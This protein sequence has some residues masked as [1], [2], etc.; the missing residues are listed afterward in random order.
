MY[1]L[2]THQLYAAQLNRGF[3]NAA[4]LKTEF[5]QKKDTGQTTAAAQ[6]STASHESFLKFMHSHKVPN[7]IQPSLDALF[8]QKPVQTVM[9]K[10]NSIV[11]TTALLKQISALQKELCGCGFTC[12]EQRTHILTH[13]KLPAWI[14]KLPT[15][16]FE[17]SV[18]DTWAAERRNGG[19]IAYAHKIADYCKTKNYPVI[20]PTK[21]A[22]MLPKVQD[23]DM[24]YACV[25]AQKIN[26]GTSSGKA[27]TPQQE[28]IMADLSTDMGFT[29]DNSGNRFNLGTV[30]AIVDTEPHEKKLLE[31]LFV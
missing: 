8:S 23:L 9:A 31:T 25:V 3:A 1:V 6:S 16:W 11:T 24:P 15:P 14:L 19:R 21:Y 22:Y 28:K 18:A 5:F 13:P 27:L 4:A 30:L 2:S 10:M 29:D 17:S 20:L 7:N 12:I 26:V